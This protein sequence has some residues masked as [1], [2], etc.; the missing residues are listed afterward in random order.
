MKSIKT[1]ATLAVA[2]LITG[3]GGGSGSAVNTPPNTSLSII[4]GDAIKGPL[5]QAKISLYKTT[6]DGQQGDLLQETTSDSNG[7]YSVT[8]NGYSGIVIAV[9]SVVSGTTM[10]DEA[11]GQTYFQVP[12]ENETVIKNAV[13]LLAGLFKG[14]MVK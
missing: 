13:T 9:A 11:T 5:A 2:A 8:L 4:Q 1:V 12:V 14:I 3:C 10:Y 6:A 7:H